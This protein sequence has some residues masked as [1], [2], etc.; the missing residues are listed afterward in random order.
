M[1][2]WLDEAEFRR[3]EAQQPVRFELVDNHPVRLPEPLFATLGGP[4]VGAGFRLRVFKDS[5]VFA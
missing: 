1:T 2:G 5:I 4:V 3:W